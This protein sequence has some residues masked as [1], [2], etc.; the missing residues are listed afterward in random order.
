MHAAIPP[1]HVRLRR[2]VRTDRPGAWLML[3]LA[4]LSLDVLRAAVVDILAGGHLWKQG[5]WLVNSELI[6]TRRGVFGSALLRIADLLGA[7]PV[8]VAGAAQI[9]VASALFAATLA[10]V[11]RMRRAR[12]VWALLLSPAFSMLFW[13][14]DVQGSMRKEMVAFAA[15]A[16]LALRAGGMGRGHGAGALRAG[17]LCADGGRDRGARG[18]RAVRAGVLCLSGRGAGAR[19]AARRA[20][21]GGLGLCALAVAAVLH[22]GANASTADWA[23]VCAPLLDRG[24]DPRICE[25]VIAWLRHDADVMRAFIRAHATW[26]VVAAQVL[27]TVAAAAP[28]AWLAAPL[29][30]LAA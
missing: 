8:T 16:F 23:A 24:V 4:F 1:F 12:A 20:G 6:E 28:L 17:R 30:W 7:S 13:W 18:E 5:D 25:G 22:A 2:T 19:G 29:A 21:S 27:T 15:L 14:H 26:Q 3:L 10:L 9:A 11:W